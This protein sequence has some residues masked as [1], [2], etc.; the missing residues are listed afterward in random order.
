MWVALILGS[1]PLKRKLDV[2][3]RQYIE[4]RY[5][6]KCVGIWVRVVVEKHGNHVGDVD[7]VGGPR[8]EVDIV[9]YEFEEGFDDLAG[10]VLDGVV[11]GEGLSRLRPSPMTMSLTSSTSEESRARRMPPEFF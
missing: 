10:A 5:V 4:R 8:G 9:S 2:R 3:E 11:E 1:A 6:V 7:V